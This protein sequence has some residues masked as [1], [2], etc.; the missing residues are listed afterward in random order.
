MSEGK[1]AERNDAIEHLFPLQSIQGSKKVEDEAKP[2][3][4]PQTRPTG[5]R[6]SM[7]RSSALQAQSSH[8]LHWRIPNQL[9]EKAR[10]VEEKLKWRDLKRNRGR[11]SNKA[12]EGLKTCK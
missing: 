6:K 7:Q 2:D 4:R 1:K 3:F 8:T 5:N 11:D 10:F 9:D 12:K